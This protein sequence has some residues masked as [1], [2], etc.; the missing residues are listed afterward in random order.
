MSQTRTKSQRVTVT[1][2]AAT[3]SQQP[4]QALSGAPVITNG[5]APRQQAP[6]GAP[7]VNRAPGTRQ[8]VPSKAPAVNHT[9]GPGQQALP[10]GPVVTRAPGPG[11]KAPSGAPVVNHAPVP[12]QQARSGAPVIY[13][14]PGPGRQVPSGA[15]VVNR[16]SEAGQQS[17]AVDSEAPQIHHKK[18]NY[19]TRAAL[20][21]GVLH[22]LI[23]FLFGGVPFLGIMYR[24]WGNAGFLLYSAAGIWV[25]NVRQLEETV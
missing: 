18:N 1:A 10:G 23:S 2:S 9:P 17:R 11:H 19:L 21:V 24:A 3:Y 16:A 20:V 25:S 7:V 14:A 13:R 12:E 8:Q 6:L 15:P 5:P 22:I 4:C